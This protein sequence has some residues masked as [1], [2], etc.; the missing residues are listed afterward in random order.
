VSSSVADRG[1]AGN[2]RDALRDDPR[3]LVSRPV[4]LGRDGKPLLG[5]KRWEMPRKDVDGCAVKDFK[6]YIA[7]R[8]LFVIGGFHLVVELGLRAQWYNHDATREDAKKIIH[9]R[10]WAPVLNELKGKENNASDLFGK[11]AIN[12]FFATCPPVKRDNGAEMPK[13]ALPKD[14][15]KRQFAIWLEHPLRLRKA[16]EFVIMTEAILAYRFKIGRSRDRFGS[17]TGLPPAAAYPE[18]VWDYMWIEPI[19]YRVSVLVDPEHVRNIVD[20]Q[21][22]V[23]RFTEQ[24]GQAKGALYWILRGL[25]GK[26]PTVAAACNILNSVLGNVLTQ[27]VPMT[28]LPNEHR[29]RIGLLEARAKPDYRMQ[30]E[31]IWELGPDRPALPQE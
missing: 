7:E 4:F 26:W 25:P 3:T 13:V 5:L 27:A 18:F 2:S 21:E 12:A 11:N 10:K 15:G 29:S 1:E 20:R 16:I 28:V 24:T 22:L 23:D 30:P 31:N 6:R 14:P 9:D 19:L 17:L 8:S